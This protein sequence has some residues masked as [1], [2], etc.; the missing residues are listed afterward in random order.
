MGKA[1]E[2]GARGV[3]EDVK[4]RM[5]STFGRIAGEREHER[6]GHAQQDEAASEREA[7]ARETEAA[8]ARAEAEIDKARQSGAQRDS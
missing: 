4:G 5:K 3:W 2:H 7:A 1:G 8:R 6:E